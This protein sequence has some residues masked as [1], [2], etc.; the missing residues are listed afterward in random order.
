VWRSSAGA[1]RISREERSGGEARTGAALEIWEELHGAGAGAGLAGELK[2]QDREAGMNIFRS[3]QH[4]APRP[5][6]GRYRPRPA[7]ADVDEAPGHRGESRGD[8]IG[9]GGEG[10]IEESP[11][12]LL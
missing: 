11:C 1:R 4:P 8:P 9:N 12:L 6:P 2:R 10:L 7:A 3:G 5:P